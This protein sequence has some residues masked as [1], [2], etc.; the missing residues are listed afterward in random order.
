[1]FKT[2]YAFLGDD[3]VSMRTRVE[4]LIAKAVEKEYRDFNLDQFSPGDASP[5][6]IEETARRNP[7]GAGRR[8]VLVRDLGGFPPADQ[9]AIAEAALR[10][11]RIEDAE[12]TFAVVAPGLDRRK[13]PYKRLRSLDQEPSG[14]IIEYPAPKPWEIDEWVRERAGT[15]SIDLHRDAA[16]ALVEL[17]GDDLAQLD[18]ELSKLA[19]Y[20]GP[21]KPV[22]AGEVETVVGRRRGESPWDLP[23]RLLGGDTAGAQILLD[24]LLAAGENPVFL[25]SAL[26]RYLLEVW[27]VALLLAAGAS[28]K[29]VIEE[30]GLRK[31]AARET[32]AA[33]RR[34]PSRAFP[35]MAA[36]LKECDA[37]LKSRSRQ[38]SLLLEQ[39]VIA[40][41]LEA[42][43]AERSGA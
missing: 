40:L 42:G 36:A 43:G 7:L 11:A 24:R 31:F 1:M 8:L 41:A 15:R 17:I 29:A 39:V 38:E 22:T 30:V 33:A 25:V 20:V 35:R 23:R 3:A 4:S 34:I 14:E 6:E 12:T 28:E 21:G 10:L 27:Q 2:V 26:T 13:K 32:F 37:G 16:E 19:L 5:I 9:E 18:G